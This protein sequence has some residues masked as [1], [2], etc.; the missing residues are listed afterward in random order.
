[1]ATDLGR[2]KI[3]VSRN[4][5]VVANMAGYPHPYTN[6]TSIPLSS[7]DICELTAKPRTSSISPRVIG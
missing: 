5:L 3:E 7:F 1:M 6:D 2:F 4:I